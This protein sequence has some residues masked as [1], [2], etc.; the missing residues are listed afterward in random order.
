MT[1][2]CVGGDI[3]QMYLAKILLNNHY[4]VQ[5]VGFSKSDWDK[6]FPVSHIE[7]K[8]PE[9]QFYCAEQLKDALTK[10]EIILGP[11]PLSKDNK[12]LNC[13]NTSDPIL[14][15]YLLD[16][17]LPSHYF[18]AGLLSNTAKDTLTKNRINYYDYLSNESFARLNAIAT[19]EG[20]ISYAIEH[21]PGNLHQRR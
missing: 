5:L 19:A 10:S 21:S 1:I 20:A 8:L 18:I 15:S 14:L 16:N 7:K 17:L 13:A 9:P 4:Q 6:A 3:R 2:T 12:T 11:L